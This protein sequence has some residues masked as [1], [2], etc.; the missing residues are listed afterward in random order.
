MSLGGTVDLSASSSPS[1]QFPKQQKKPNGM[2]K[3][4][5]LLGNLNMEGG[6]KRMGSLSPKLS[7]TTE[8]QVHIGEEVLFEM[9]AA[10]CKCNFKICYCHLQGK[11]ITR[12]KQQVPD[13][14]REAS[15]P[16][17]QR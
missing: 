5:H 12:E 2:G 6:E 16:C 10:G 13:F 17:T 11:Q 7:T 3:G 8:F 15:S 4:V 1:P 14:A 9:N